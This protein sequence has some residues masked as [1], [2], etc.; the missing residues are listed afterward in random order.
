MSR[1]RILF[2]TFGGV[3]IVA[4][5][6]LIWVLLSNAMLKTPPV[7]L[8][9]AGPFGGPDMSAPNMGNIGSDGLVYVEV[10]ADNVQAV[11]AT[12]NR[13][14]YYSRE[15]EVENIWQDG[16]AVYKINTAVYEGVT[17]ISVQSSS[18]TKNVIVNDT[19]A[20]I[21]YDGD[22]S[23]LETDMKGVSG[24][25]D[26]DEFQMLV[27]YEDIFAL[28][29]DEIVNAGYTEYGGEDCIFVSAISGTLGYRTDYY[30]SV[31]LGLL[32][33]AF[34]FD[35]DTLVYRM[36]AGTC[37]L[38]TPGADAFRLPDDRVVLS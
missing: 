2:M 25:K 21:W 15:L 11:V 29:K 4:A 32:V 16:S 28:D 8:P 3:F 7:I 13:P 19:K 17:S 5:I 27:T 33:A 30:I 35:G 34:E 6:I 12:L 23:F 26:T 9:D 38:N 24:I 20:Y 10:T 22:R 14:Q 36:S 1:K 18:N 37:D 31:P